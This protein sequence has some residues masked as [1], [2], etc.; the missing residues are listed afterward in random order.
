MMIIPGASFLNNPNEGL[1]TFI[2]G[3]LIQGG[4]GERDGHGVNDI[5]L[6]FTTYSYSG[7]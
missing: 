5:H 7:N 3:N 1:D 4:G 6:F 2:E